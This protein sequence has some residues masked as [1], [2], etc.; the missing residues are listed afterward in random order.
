[1]DH[2]GDVVSVWPH[3]TPVQVAFAKMT[4][5]S[6]LKARFVQEQGKQ[7]RMYCRKILKC[8]SHGDKAHILYLAEAFSNTFL[9]LF[10]VN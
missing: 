10:T 3:S 8:D 4:K 6:I 7:Y 9:N 2:N 1:V 5:S